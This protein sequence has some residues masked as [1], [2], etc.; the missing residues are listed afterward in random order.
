MQTK[1]GLLINGIVPRPI[2]LVSSLSPDGKTVNVSPYSFF[3]A[4]S[5]DPPMICFSAINSVRSNAGA[6]TVVEK[7][8]V[9]NARANKEFVGTL[10]FKRVAWD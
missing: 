7:D 6:K 2:A 1:Y 3:N 10:E 4:L 8:S 5:S 9:V